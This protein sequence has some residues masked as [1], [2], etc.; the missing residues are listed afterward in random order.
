M[1]VQTAL[2]TG[3]LCPLRVLGVRKL[4]NSKRDENDIL[5]FDFKIDWV[6]DVGTKKDLERITCS[7]AIECLRV[8]TQPG[9]KGD[10]EGRRASPPKVDIHRCGPH[11]REGPRKRHGSPPESPCQKYGTT[12]RE[13]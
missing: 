9:S 13:R 3:R 11:V 8:L 10:I 4:K 1:P 12:P 6:C 2:G 5:K 7:I